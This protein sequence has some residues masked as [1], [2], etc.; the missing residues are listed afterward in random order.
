MARQGSIQSGNNAGREGPVEA[1]GVA[2]RKD[3]LADLKVLT[4]PDG[5]RGWAAQGN[6]DLEQGQIM[7]WTGTDQGSA[8]F[9]AIDKL[10]GR[11]GGTLDDMEV[12]HDMAGAVPDQ[13]GPGSTRNR[14]D[15]SRPGVL[16]QLGRGDVNDGAA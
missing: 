12:R 14:E 4:R 3:L 7:A 10:Y 13:T 1:E 9:P 15:V 11:F 6:A 8:K 2:D 16:N 5:D